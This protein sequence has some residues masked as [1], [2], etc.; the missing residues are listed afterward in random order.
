MRQVDR[1]LALATLAVGDRFAWRV[2]VVVLAVK[3]SK[4]LWDEAVVQNCLQ[5]VSEHIQLLL[6]QERA[7]GLW[8]MDRVNAVHVAGLSCAQLL[9]DLCA[10]SVMSHPIARDPRTFLIIAVEGL[11][12]GIFLQLLHAIEL[13]DDVGV[14]TGAVVDV[15]SI[16]CLPH[17]ALVLQ[18]EREPS[19]PRTNIALTAGDMPAI[20]GPDIG[21]WFQ[22]A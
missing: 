3:Q 4:A 16:L 8:D 19:H 9:S 7:V 14:N 6:T 12:L 10:E 18:E 15:H 20:S 5:A 13:L 2:A 21:W 11:V 17:E 1:E 22:S